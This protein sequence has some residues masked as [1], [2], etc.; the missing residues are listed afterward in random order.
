LLLKI[1]TDG[2]SRN[3]PGHAGIG[4]VIYDENNFIVKTYKEY[5]GKATNNQAEY[6]ALI[7]AVEQLKKLEEKEKIKADSIE[8]YADSELLV[9][10]INFD[11]RV[12]DPDLALLNNKFHVL[13][14]KLNKPY[15]ILHIERAK[16]SNADL[17]ANKAIDSKLK[18]RSTPATAD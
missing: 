16:N 11:Y 9:N 15:R 10:Q 8:F 1:Y 17:L 14:K 6:T 18:K 4:I 13:M 12:K 2:A 7:R 5:I 3:N